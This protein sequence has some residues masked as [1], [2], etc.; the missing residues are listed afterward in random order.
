MYG[1]AAFRDILAEKLRDCQLESPGPSGPTAWTAPAS[2]SILHG[3]PRYCF[4]A[5]PYGRMVE[6]RS[7]QPPRTLSPRHQ[8]ALD[9][10]VRGGASLHADFTPAELRTAFRDLAR[11][12]HP[13]RHPGSDE[14]A[15][16]RFARMFAELNES[17]R[18]LL[19]AAAAP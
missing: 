19:T 2:G 6:A 5:T 12:Y 8:R 9:V 18:V 10:L 4:G 13:D 3:E 7:Q 14:A 16:S 1:G 17:Y 15:S 11:R